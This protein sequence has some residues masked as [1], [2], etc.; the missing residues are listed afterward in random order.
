[1]R[2]GK[3]IGSGR[4]KGKSLNLKAYLTEKDIK[5]FVEYV[6]DSYNEDTRLM[7]W[8]GDHIFGKAPQPI[9]NGED[10]APFVFQISEALVKKNGIKSGTE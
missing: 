5:E 2:G 9:T 10:G 8:L 3:R 1:M 6:L 4:K 7:T